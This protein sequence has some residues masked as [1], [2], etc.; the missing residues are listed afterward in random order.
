MQNLPIRCLPS[1]PLVH[2]LLPSHS[3]SLPFLSHRQR[4]KPQPLSW[5]SP[6]VPSCH[7]SCQPLVWLPLPGDPTWLWGGVVAVRGSGLGGA[8][9]RGVRR[10]VGGTGFLNCLFF[11]L[12]WCG[13][14]FWRPCAP[15]KNPF[16]ILQ[17]N[18]P[19]PQYWVGFFSSKNMFCWDTLISSSVTVA[20]G[21]NR[22]KSEF[23]QELQI[24]TVIEEI[25]GSEH[26]LKF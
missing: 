15:P 26:K 25:V 11:V 18:T 6:P 16:G 24:R 21:I 3:S 5:S 12:D 8:G 22:K 10:G 23:T 14:D 13:S 4:S 17:T 9:I 2:P 1:S 7:P 20:L 19:I